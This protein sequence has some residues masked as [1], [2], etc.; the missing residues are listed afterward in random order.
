MLNEILEYLQYTDPGHKKRL[1]A[2]L[3][4]DKGFAGVPR[5]LTIIARKELEDRNYWKEKS[6]EKRKS[7]RQDVRKV[8]EKWCFEDN[9]NSLLQRINIP[10]PVKKKTETDKKYKARLKKQIKITKEK[11]KTDLEDKKR[12]VSWASKDIYLP[13]NFSTPNITA[14]N[15]PRIISGA[16]SD[17]P[18]KHYMLICDM[19]F[20]EDLYINRLFS[21]SSKKEEDKKT[22]PVFTKNNDPEAGTLTK[23]YR[24]YIERFLKLIAVYMYTSK[25]S[26]E[27]STKVYIGSG[28]AA[29]WMDYA[30]FCLG[31]HSTTFYFKNEE[32][33]KD[34]PVF[35]NRYSRWEMNRKILKRY[36]FEITE[37]KEVNKKNNKNEKK[38]GKEL[39]KTIDE[40]KKICLVMDLEEGLRYPEYEEM[41]KRH[42]L[43]DTAKQ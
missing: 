35:S 29:N 28:E 2:K 13:L 9:E 41:V 27:E 26:Q 38:K 37:Y 12:P 25:A 22:I 5:A 40:E 19:R 42:S 33:G 4:T 7:I 32:D 30:P 18:L 15:F 10:E 20:F 36:G 11:I 39:P 43:R 1:L 34:I 17:G 6:P 8:L 31:N 3:I 14:V 21:A 16:I 24:E 23:N